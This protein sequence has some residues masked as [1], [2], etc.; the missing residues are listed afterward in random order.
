MEC[1]VEDCGQPVKRY[2]K[3]QLCNRHYLRLLRHGTTDP[4]TKPPCKIDGCD[5]EAYGHGWCSKHYQRWRKTGDPLQVRDRPSGGEHHSWT[6]DQVGYNDM[7]ARV[8]RTRG[9]ASEY[10][11]VGCGN[12]ADDWS[13]DANDPDELVAKEGQAAGMRYSLDPEHYE[14]RCK[15]CHTRYDR[16]GSKNVNAK[17]TED[18]VR[19]IRRRAAAGET[20]A[21]LALEFGISPGNVSNIIARR[22]WAHVA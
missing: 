4:R 12:R 3:K 11:C 2:K 1:L 17:L 15:K 19:E 22:A 7:H 5:D 10:T 8:R 13:Y 6:G 9:P 16:A 18:D 21:A 20:H 14:P